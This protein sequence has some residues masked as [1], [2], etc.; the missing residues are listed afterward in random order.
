MID[1]MKIISKMI[2]PKDEIDFENNETPKIE[3]PRFQQRKENVKE[4]MESLEQEK[5]KF[6]EMVKI[7]AEKH[8]NSTDLIKKYEDLQILEEIRVEKMEKTKL[9]L[10]DYENRI[11]EILER[12]ESHKI[13]AKVKYLALLR[14][15]QEKLSTIRELDFHVASINK[16]MEILQT[17]N[18]TLMNYQTSIGKKILQ[19][20][21]QVKFFENEAKKLKAEQLTEKVQK[22]D[23]ELLKLENF[24]KLML[25]ISAFEE[26]ITKIT[27]IIEELDTKQRIYLLTI[28]EFLDQSLNLIEPKIKH[29]KLPF[30]PF[31]ETPE[32]KS[33]ILF[34]DIQGFSSL[35]DLDAE[36]METALFLYNV[37]IQNILRDKNFKGYEVKKTRNCFFCAFSSPI[38]ALNFALEVQLKFLALPWPKN[39][40]T[41]EECKKESGKNGI[42]FKGLRLKIGINNGVF[43]FKNEKNI[44]RKDYKGPAVDLASALV[45]KAEGGM[46][47]VTKEFWNLIE[48]HQKELNHEIFV[49]DLGEVNLHQIKEKQHLMIILPEELKER[50]SYFE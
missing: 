15:F 38:N 26:S 39:L 7:L 34:T 8:E 12:N 43:E 49:K 27:K 13:Q 16:K 3:E 31:L 4:L 22:I 42:I 2:D 9:K 47:L 40:L 35:M 37:Q 1:P 50:I 29:Y 48:P 33:V 44:D 28:T 5:K 36:E 23:L 46:I 17:E 21:S 32:G 10:K 19:L 41:F 14:Q 18:E 24:D 6:K 25:E 20:Q 11:S 30:D 45:S